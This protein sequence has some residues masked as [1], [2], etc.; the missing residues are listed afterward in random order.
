MLGA[1]LQHHPRH[2]SESGTARRAAWNTPL[3]V[4]TFHGREELLS[5]DGVVGLLGRHAA[6]GENADGF[7]MLARL[8]YA[9]D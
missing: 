5:A 6:T 9:V 8:Q 2:H 4:Q 1:T 7:Q 3:A